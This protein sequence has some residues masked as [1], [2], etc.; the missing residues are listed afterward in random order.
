M[1]PIKY[2]SVMD[3]DYT[4][5]GWDGEELLIKHPDGRHVFRIAQA[6]ALDL[7]AKLKIELPPPA[8]T[9]FK[10]EELND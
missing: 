3:T 5:L 7:L 4:I 9:K 8:N 2:K 6:E 10:W 1:T